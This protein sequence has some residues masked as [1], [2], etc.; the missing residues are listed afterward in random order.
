[1]EEEFVVDTFE[2][3]IDES[4]DLDLGGG[5]P[6]ESDMTIDDINTAVM[7][8]DYY[9]TPG[10]VRFLGYGTWY[11]EGATKDPWVFSAILGK[12]VTEDTTYKYEIYFNGEL[13]NS[14]SVTMVADPFFR[15]IEVRCEYDIKP[16]IYCFVLYDGNDSDKILG[17][18][19]WE[20][21]E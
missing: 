1:M 16:G 18:H 9:I 4:C 19:W 6:I 20:Y 14:D 5:E 17:A 21:R 10:L 2:W 13:V 3:I 11:E 15:Q 12:A 7:G 8:N